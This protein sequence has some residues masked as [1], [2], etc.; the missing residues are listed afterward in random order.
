MA[1]ALRKEEFSTSVIRKIV[2]CHQSTIARV[3]KLKLETDD[4]ERIV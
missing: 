1:V 2:S 3:F 4:V